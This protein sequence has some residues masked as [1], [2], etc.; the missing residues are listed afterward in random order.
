MAIPEFVLQSFLDQILGFLAEK[1]KGFIQDAVTKKKIMVGIKNAANRFEN[2]FPDQELAKALTSNTKFHD[3]ESVRKSVLYLLEHPFDPLPKIQIEGQFKSALPARLQ[4][5]VDVAAKFFID[6]LQ[7]ELIGVEKLREI[8]ALVYEKRTADATERTASGVGELVL[9]QKILDS[10]LNTAK[11]IYLQY[12]V[13][14]NTY[15]DPRGIMQTRR[16]ITLK[17][18]EIYVALNAEHET[19]S[20]DIERLKNKARTEVDETVEEAPDFSYKESAKRTEPSAEI[21]DLAQAIDKHP[22]VVILGDPGAGKTTLIRFLV[23]RFAYAIKNQDERVVDNENNDYGVPLLPVHIRIANY[24]DAFARNRS[25]TLRDYLLENCDGGGADKTAL[26]KV[27]AL[28]LDAG[29]AIILLDGLDEIVDAGDRAEIGRRIEQLV[30]SCKLGTRFVITSRIAGYRSAPLVGD[31]THYT[32]RELGIPQIEKFLHKWCPA[33]ERAQTPEALQVEIDKR[34]QDEISGILKALNDNPGV[35]RLAANPLMLTILALIH[36]AGSRLP[37]RRV[38]LYELAVKTLLEDWEWFRGIPKEHTISETEAIRLLGPL[39]FWLHENKP[40]GIASEYE[41]KIKLAE[42]LAAW[43]NLPPESE[44]IQISVDDFLRRVREHTGIFVERS[45]RQYGFMHLTF[46]EYFSA[47]ELVRRRNTAI[48]RIYE[49]RNDPRWEEPIKLAIGFISNDYPEDAADYICTA[50]LAEGAEAKENEFEPSSYENVLYRNLLF[51]VSC[52]GDCIGLHEGFKQD[53]ITR[54][55]S[56]YLDIDGSGK[57]KPLCKMIEKVLSD[58][59]GFETPEIIFQT[60]LINMKSNVEEIRQRAVKV[61]GLLAVH[62]KKLVQSIISALADASASVQAQAAVSLGWLQLKSDYIYDALIKSVSLCDS[63]VIGKSVESLNMLGYLNGSVVDKL[64]LTCGE[65]DKLS[66]YYFISSISNMRITTP[67]L[68]EWMNQLVQDDT[69]M[70]SLRLR[71]FYWL[72]SKGYNTSE[73]IRNSLQDSKLE[74]YPDIS[75]MGE[76]T[77]DSVLDEIGFAEAQEI[78]SLG[79][80]EQQFDENIL[81][82]LIFSLDSKK[83]M[84]RNSAAKGLVRLYKRFGIKCRQCVTTDISNKLCLLLDDPIS[85]ESS[86][87]L[88][89]EDS[90]TYN[91][92]WEA[93]W[94]VETYG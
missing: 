67:K 28:T 77:I 59:R 12:L 82:R 55:L 21:V 94:A 65:R 79:D 2:E 39:A 44:Q 13:D 48:K 1:G 40:K 42:E 47:R 54:L 81:T 7:E 85:F 31:F 63:R 66:K 68:V 76:L 10:D 41:T 4:D 52:M 78:E 92:I 22:R 51:A 37:S 90:E 75:D 71:A 17:L 73:R 64:L 91:S 93:L 60:L 49:R 84:V 36:R 61:L 46:Q 29:K 86:G 26:K 30:V 74:F 19:R 8:L 34:A 3:L 80:G 72:R 18:D 43:R 57:F 32:L 45:S 11:E 9:M 16:S 70:R 50:V 15:I 56:V 87:G 6:R 14:T 58:L 69:E 24:A 23:L 33:A 20:L 62:D 89:S 25:L 35:R 88:S 53:L 38:E 83:P 27:L 5:G